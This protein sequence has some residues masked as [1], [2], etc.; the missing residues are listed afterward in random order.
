MGGLGSKDAHFILNLIRDG[1]FPFG[2][3]FDVDIEVSV[4]S[5]VGRACKCANNLLSGLHG[6]DIFRVEH[7]LSITHMFVSLHHPFTS[8]G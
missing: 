1:S 5:L 3:V 7:C 6:N 2:F 8:V 4:V